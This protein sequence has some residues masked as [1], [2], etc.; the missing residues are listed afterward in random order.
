MSG[1]THLPRL[2]LSPHPF[3]H[4]GQ[5]TDTFHNCILASG[6]A[7][8]LHKKKRVIS[9]HAHW[10][11][12][13]TV[14]A[15]IQTTRITKAGREHPFRPLEMSCQDKSVTGVELGRKRD[16]SQI[17]GTVPPKSG[18]L[19]TMRQTTSSS[20][21]PL[22]SIT[23][24]E[25]QYWLLRF[26]HEVRKKNGSEYPPNILLHLCTGIVR[27]LRHPSHDIFK[28]SAFAEFRSS[29]NAEMKQLQARGLGSKQRQ[30]EPITE[31]EDLLWEKGLLDDHTPDALL[32][33]V[34]Y[35]NGLLRSGKE[36]HNLRHS[37]SQIETVERDGERPYLLYTEDCSNTI[38]GVNGSIAK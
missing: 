18:R 36:H 23:L 15:P 24:S 20:I 10:H 26:I 14:N 38:Q 13:R 34:V 21:P 12:V 16:R 1:Q 11:D 19:A 22:S 7:T 3:L 35:M 27:Y 29:L 8:N 31:E 25:L 6:A 9:T 5:F 2:Q 37:P 4:P 32:N 33:T 28:D 17:V 30:A